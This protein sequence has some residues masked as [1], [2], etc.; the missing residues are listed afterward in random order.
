[1]DSL[2]LLEGRRRAADD[3]DVDKAY[4]RTLL[5]LGWVDL[6]Q[7]HFDASARLGRAC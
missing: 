1:M 6:E 3:P 2:E 4:A 5:E 7:G